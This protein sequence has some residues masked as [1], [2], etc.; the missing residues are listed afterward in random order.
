M[1]SDQLM[2]TPLTSTTPRESKGITSGSTSTSQ[3]KSESIT[4]SYQVTD[5]QLHSPLQIME[6]CCP[7]FQCHRPHLPATQDILESTM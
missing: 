5:L 3:V 7:A 1:S 2:S 4:L 6:V